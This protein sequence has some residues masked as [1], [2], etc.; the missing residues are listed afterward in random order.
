MSK[1][2]ITSHSLKLENI[3]DGLKKL[4]KLTILSSEEVGEASILTV[5]TGM[6]I[7][8][9]Y[10]QAKFSPLQLTI[11]PERKYRIF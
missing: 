8:E 11:S 2:L 4:E 9:I 3:L 6:Q 5:E 1:Y 7:T 10:K